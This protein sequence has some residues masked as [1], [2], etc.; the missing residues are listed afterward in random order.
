MMRLGFLMASLALLY[1]EVPARAGPITYTETVTGVVGSL[2]ASSFT[3]ALVT[4]TMNA[5]TA[6]IQQLSPGVYFLTHSATVTVAGIGT[7]SITS[8]PI[9]VLV[10]QFSM[11][12]GFTALNAFAILFTD[13]IG[14]GGYDLTTSIGPLN[15]LSEAG[16]GFTL[17][18][19]QG[20]FQMTVAP[21]ERSTFTATLSA[22]PEPTTFSLLGI[23]VACV[24]A[25]GWR[26]RKL[27]AHAFEKGA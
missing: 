16:A 7:A 21:G 14:F 19:T 23:A 9:S 12:A 4:Y 26:R 2:G 15:G 18:T 22:V 17:A 24:V 13:N 27:V 3:N 8:P 1:G 6:N 11:D 20:N 10:N 25:F 5:D